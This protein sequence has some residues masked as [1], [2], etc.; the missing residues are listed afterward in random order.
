M[1]YSL[2]PHTFTK[3]EWVKIRSSIIGAVD[4][5]MSVL[6]ISEAL[7]PKTDRKVIFCGVF[8][9]AL[10]KTYRYCKERKTTFV[11]MKKIKDRLSK[12]EYARYN[13][14]VRFGFARRPSTKNG[15]YI[16]DLPTIEDFF[17]RKIGVSEYFV[18]DV[19]SKSYT[20]STTEVLV[21]RVPK[22][23]EVIEEFG[24]KFTEYVTHA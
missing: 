3:S 2:G 23:E 6:D 1:S 10:I 13:D 7:A 17:M 4:S 9:S 16:F 15:E 5:G 24:E 20:L 8:V 11:E 19:R 12:S 21:D 18:R 22:V 14:L